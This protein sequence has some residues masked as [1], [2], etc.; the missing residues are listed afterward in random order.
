[1]LV[2]SRKLS[3][4]EYSLKKLLSAERAGNCVLEAAKGERRT[5]RDREDKPP[6]PAKSVGSFYGGLLNN[7]ND[8]SKFMKQDSTFVGRKSV[9]HSYA[10]PIHT[11]TDADC[12]SPVLN[13][14]LV[15][16]S[17]SRP[18]SHVYTPHRRS[19]L[20]SPPALR[21]ENSTLDAS[22]MTVTLKKVA[23]TQRRSVVR[24]RKSAQPSFSTRRK[25]FASKALDTTDPDEVRSS[26]VRDKENQYQERLETTT[27]VGRSTRRSNV[28][29]QYLDRMLR[30]QAHKKPI[31]RTRPR[32]SARSHMVPRRQRNP[33]AV[34]TS[35]EPWED[36]DEVL[37][38]AMVKLPSCRDL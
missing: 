19:R 31:V 28:I 29:S 12:A 35:V 33:E 36:F 30:E 27:S 16:R 15:C 21:L 34:R 9:R 17:L 22:D 13:S 24:R 3:C 10:R 1:M 6:S 20:L 37:V 23:L 5:V 26:P 18:S 7:L 11:E 32:V 8:P 4:L 25:T 38:G 2:M 14:S